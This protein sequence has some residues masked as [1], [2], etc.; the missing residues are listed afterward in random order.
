MRLPDY[1]SAQSDTRLVM[2]KLEPGNGYYLDAT[3]EIRWEFNVKIV[4]QVELPS[5][6]DIEKEW[7]LTLCQTYQN[8]KYYYLKEN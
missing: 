4:E 5:D 8:Q 1:A 7:N 3:A 2:Y 6:M